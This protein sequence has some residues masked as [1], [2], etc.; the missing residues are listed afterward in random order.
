MLAS[1]VF[2]MFAHDA[3][4]SIAALNRGPRL[5]SLAGRLIEPSAAVPCHP[6]AGFITGQVLG[7]DGGGSIAG[8]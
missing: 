6:D 1:V 7:V 2:L 8:R 4:R 5:W 3:G